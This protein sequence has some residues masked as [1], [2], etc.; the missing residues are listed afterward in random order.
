MQNSNPIII[1]LFVY[2]LFKSMIL[3]LKPRLE[4]EPIVFLLFTGKQPV[5]E[6]PD[7]RIRN[8]GVRG[9]APADQS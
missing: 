7:E 2:Q 9:D 1:A 5:T 4:K 8:L 3:D 6:N